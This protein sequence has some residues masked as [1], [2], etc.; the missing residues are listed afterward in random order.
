M[1]LSAERAAALF[2]G[3]N[4]WLL[5]NNGVGFSYK[6]AART[7]LIYR[8]CSQIR[9]QVVLKVSSV[10]AEDEL[11]RSDVNSEPVWVFENCH[12]VVRV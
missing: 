2:S 10:F 3:E 5:V 6:T 12:G 9:P 11:G 8:R 7:P 1:P 4:V